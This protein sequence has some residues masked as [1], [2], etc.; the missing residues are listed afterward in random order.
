MR[1]F[2]LQPS[3]EDLATPYQ[4]EKLFDAWHGQLTPR[5]W[6]RIIAGAPSIALEVHQ[7]RGGSATPDYRH[8]AA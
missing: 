8:D 3:R 7:L 4:R 1:R 5:W 6:T 2:E